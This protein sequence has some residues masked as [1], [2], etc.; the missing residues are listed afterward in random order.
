MKIITGALVTFACMVSLSGCGDYVPKTTFDAEWQT[1]IVV[2]PATV[3]ALFTVTNTGDQAAV[4]DC[5]VK[6]YD[7]EGGA[8]TGRFRG[9]LE[10]LA[11]G[12]KVTGRADITITSE[13][14]AYATDG[15]VSCEPALGQ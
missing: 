3:T 6:A 14:A 15:E 11:P 1:N 12:E 10:E 5:I 2:N 4:P 13:G 7:R 9:D 8:Y